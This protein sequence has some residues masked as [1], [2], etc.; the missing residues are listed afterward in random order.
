M[1]KVSGCN[2]PLQNQAGFLEWWPRTCQETVLVTGR[3]GSVSSYPSHNS[4][5]FTLSF[6]FYI[7]EFL[8]KFPLI[9]I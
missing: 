7:L 3:E 8:L 6:L 1:G 5:V 2:W 4:S 9:Q